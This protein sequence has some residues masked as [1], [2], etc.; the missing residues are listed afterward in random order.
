MQAEYDAQQV[1]GIDVHPRS[2]GDR[3]DDRG[4][5]RLDSVR[6]ANDLMALK[7]STTCG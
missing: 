3:A 4:G 7:A 6:I 5:E 2:V 1:L